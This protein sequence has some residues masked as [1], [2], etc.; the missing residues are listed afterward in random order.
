MAKRTG[1]ARTTDDNLNDDNSTQTDAKKRKSKAR[2]KNFIAP[3][4]NDQ[5][6]LSNDDE[7]MDDAHLLAHVGEI[8]KDESLNSEIKDRLKGVIGVKAP[9]QHPFLFINPICELLNIDAMP[10]V[11]GL[12]HDHQV[13]LAEMIKDAYMNGRDFTNVL[14]RST[15]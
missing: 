13:T 3:R 5:M 15:F 12:A 1:G 6:P 2:G 9:R 14:G 4:T 10:I 11:L 7:N 8:P